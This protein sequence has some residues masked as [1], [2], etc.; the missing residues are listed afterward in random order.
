MPDRQ[1]PPDILDHLPQRAAPAQIVDMVSEVFTTLA[2]E[3]DAAGITRFIPGIEFTYGL[4][5]PVLRQ[6]ARLTIGN[7]ATDPT[8]CLSI[9]RASWPRP[10]RE[11]RLY[12]IFL[13]ERIR[14]AEDILWETG[15]AWLDGIL[16]WEDC[17]QMCSAVFSRALNHNPF[18]MR[19]LEGWIHSEHLWTRRAALVTTTYLRRADYEEELAATLDER[20]LAMCTHLLH[21]PEP[22]IQK[23]VDWA[24]RAVLARHY[25]LAH[26]WMLGHAARDLPG[27][28]RHSLRLSAR[29]LHD[30]DRD[31]MLERLKA[32][33]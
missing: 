20:A 32:S 33:G 29:K 12:A 4:R 25:D 15:A 7:Y 16:T 2:D 27:Y 14:L 26:G 31:E 28:A 30:G 17:D 8:L 6:L 10:S 3:Q 18:Y 11:H 19:T 5:I 22:Y 23:A 24:I 21:D 9:A 1:A 13:V